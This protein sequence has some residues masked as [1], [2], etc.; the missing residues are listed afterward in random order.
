[1][2]FLLS[3]LVVS[4]A[5]NLKCCFS[6]DIDITYSD[7]VSILIGLF[8]FIFAALAIIISLSDKKFLEI[9]KQAGVFKSILFHYWL[10]C[11]LYLSSVLIISILQIFKLS[12]WFDYLVLFLLVYSVFFSFEL[13]KTTINFGIYRE[14]YT[15]KK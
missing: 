9:L 3:V 8:A 6:I 11:V 14:K 13:V 2:D 15:V 5:V 7:V 1:M 10:G 12:G 4:I